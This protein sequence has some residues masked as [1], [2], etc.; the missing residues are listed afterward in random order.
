MEITTIK[1]DAQLR[2]AFSVDR[3]TQFCGRLLPF[4]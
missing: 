3:A 2:E 4:F 1:P